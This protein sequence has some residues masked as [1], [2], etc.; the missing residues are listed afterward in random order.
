[1]TLPLIP[2]RP[3]SATPE[4]GASS[5]LPPPQARY[6]Q[7][8]A[9]CQEAAELRAAASPE[10]DPLRAA[11]ALFQSKLLSFLGQLERRQEEQQLLRELGRV[12]SEVGARERLPR[13]RCPSGTRAN[14][15]SCPLPQLAGLQL[16]CGQCPARARRGEG[17]ELQCLQ[18]SFQKLSVEFALEKLQEMKAQVRRMQSSQGLAAWTEARHRYQESRQ[19][20]QEML[21][22]LQ[23][24]WGAQ[25]EGQG[26]AC[27]PPGS[28]SAAPRQ[29]APLCIAA[30]SPRR[31][32]LGGKGPGEQPAPRAKG[33]GQPQASSVPCPTLGAE[34]SCPQPRG[35]GHRAPHRGSADTSLPSPEGRASPGAAGHLAQDHSQPPQRHPFTLPPR[36]RFLGA[37]PSCAPSVPLGTASAPGTRGLPAEKRAEATQYFQVSSQSSFSSEDSDSQNSTEESPA[38]SLA[39]P[40]DLQGPRAP[41]PPEKSPQIVYLENHHAKSPAKANAK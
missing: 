5:S 13:E 28:G 29:E 31:G 39:L 9:L 14:S 17:Q 15:C 27:S 16:D 8:L 40:R 12:S 21:A 1:M 2:A 7:G 22:E 36:A 11:A 35:H 37:D 3:G 33:P 20:L 34:P 10:A 25:A 30:T 38:A 24:A 19:V 32:V 6:R 41:W 4:H 26:D 23:E 18:S